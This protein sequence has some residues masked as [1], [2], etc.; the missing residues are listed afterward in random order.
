MSLPQTFVL[1]FIL[2][3]HNLIHCTLFV[4]P[5]L[6]CVL[7]TVYCVLGLVGLEVLLNWGQCFV[8]SVPSPSKYLHSICMYATKQ[9][10]SHVCAILSTCRAHF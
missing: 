4:G 1:P 6:Y 7:C 8:Y 3:S 5:P 2:H 9:Q 10:M